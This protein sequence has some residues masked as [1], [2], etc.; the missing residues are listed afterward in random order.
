VKH[1]VAQAAQPPEDEL[2]FRLVSRNNELYVQ[3]SQ[4]NDQGEMVNRLEVRSGAWWS[5][6]GAFMQELH[7]VRQVLLGVKDA[8]N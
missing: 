6:L 7:N 4:L 2:D 3:V 8:S 5:Q 1:L